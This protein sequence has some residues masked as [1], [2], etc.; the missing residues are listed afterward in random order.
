MYYIKMVYLE[1]VEVKAVCRARIS[2]VLMTL[3]LP[4]DNVD[5]GNGKG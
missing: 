1:A 3:S 5:R 4:F 2:T